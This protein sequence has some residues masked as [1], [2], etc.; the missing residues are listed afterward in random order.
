M[1]KTTF[2]C[3]IV[4]QKKY[5]QKQIHWY[6]PYSKS[7]IKANIHLFK[8]VVSWC[9]VTQKT[10]KLLIPKTKTLART[11]YYYVWPRYLIILLNLLSWSL[12]LFW[13]LQC[14][15]LS[16]VVQERETLKIN[17]KILCWFFFFLRNRDNW[18]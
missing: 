5:F 17:H 16:F 10:S 7:N 12:L 6:L 18:P 2:I 14:G 8:R 1:Q 9:R 4:I 3:K 15:L 13:I 11:Q